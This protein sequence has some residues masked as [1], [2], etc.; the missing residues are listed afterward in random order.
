M[1][2]I[3]LISFDDCQFTDNKGFGSLP[4]RVCCGVLASVVQASAVL[5]FFASETARARLLTSRSTAHG[6]GC[7]VCRFLPLNST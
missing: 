7:V 3:G 6:F 4:S 1:I 5:S 2:K